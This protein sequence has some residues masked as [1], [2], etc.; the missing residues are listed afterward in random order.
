MW[1]N[2]DPKPYTQE[3]W[4]VHVKA[5]DFSLWGKSSYARSQKPLFITVHNT[6]LPTL[7]MWVESG[8]SH[9]ARLQNLES[10]YEKNLGWHAGPHAFISRN[11]INGFSQL[12]A[13]G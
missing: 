3:Q 4:I 2:F 7:K 13:P 11:F 1:P 12:N 10:Y 8:P 5:T 9:D 6:S